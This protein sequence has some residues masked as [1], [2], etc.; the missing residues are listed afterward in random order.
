MSIKCVKIKTELFEVMDSCT[1]DIVFI[2]PDENEAIDFCNR[3]IIKG[4]DCLLI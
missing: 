1:E 4:V 2:T 3:Q